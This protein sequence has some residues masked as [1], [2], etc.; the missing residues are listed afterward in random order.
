MPDSS[1]GV[2]PPAVGSVVVMGV[3]GAGKTTLGIALAATL[4]RPFLDADDL[5]DAPARAQMAR[6]EGLTEDARGPWIGRVADALA[7]FRT[8]GM[9]GVVA[10][11]ALLAAHRERLLAADPALRFVWLDAPPSLLRR[12][13]ATRRGHFA[14]PDLLGSQFAA[15]EVPTGPAVVHLDAAAPVD[16]LVG[17]VRRALRL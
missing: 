15:L 11:S 8:S 14:G 2:L 6:G 10:C 5:H 1:P 12:R 13:L 7:R 9:P 17:E 16:A 3:S 4:G